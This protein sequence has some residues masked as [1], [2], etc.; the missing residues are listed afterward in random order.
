MPRLGDKPA[1]HKRMSSSN[2]EPGGS[3]GSPSP[4]ASLLSPAPP[5]S[6]CPKERAH[7]C[8]GT[9]K[10]EYGESERRKPADVRLEERG[11]ERLLE[12]HSCHHPLFRM[13]VC[14]C[15]LI[16]RACVRVRMYVCACVCISLPPSL[17]PSLPL[18]LSLARARALSVALP[19]SL[20]LSRPSLYV[21]L[22]QPAHDRHVID[23]T[24]NHLQR[25]GD[26]GSD[27][28]RRCILWQH[29]D[30]ERHASRSVTSPLCTIPQ[31]YDIAGDRCHHQHHY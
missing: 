1:P 30:T 24:R 6:A 27:R 28:A 18:P 26:G 8:Q 21:S 2:R 3:S 11:A 7:F 13:S 14:S 4:P 5:P 12:R 25:E 9:I 29:L 17:P 22:F 16:V 15:V 23:T 19:P 10:V 20:P 31:D